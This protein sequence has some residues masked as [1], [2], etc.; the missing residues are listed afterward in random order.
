MTQFSSFGEKFIQPS[1]IT[2]LMAD[3]GKANAS[4]D[5]EICMLGGGNPASIPAV[6]TIFQNEMQALL[7]QPSDFNNMLGNYDGPNGS[8]LFIEN[9]T[10]LL[11]KRYK[12]D[13]SEKNICLTNGSQSSFFNLFNLFAGDMP[14]GKK[15]TILFPLAPE[16]IGYFDQGLS[17][18]MFK[19]NKPI[20][21]ELSDFEFKYYIDF[22]QLKID[23]SIAAICVSRPTN[24]TGNVLTDTEMQKLDE[25]TQE[26]QIPLIVD[27][28]YGFPFP[29]A[30]YTDV[31]PHWHENIILTMS[32]SK[33]GLPGT[34]TGIIIAR[35]DIINAM[36]S[37][38]AIMSLAPTS[39]GAN[40]VNRLMKTGEIIHLREDI[41]RP[42]YQDKSIFACQLAHSLFSDMPVKIHKSEGA[43]FLWLWCPDLPISTTVLYHRLA[44]RKVFVI[45]S[46][47]FFPNV[48]QIWQHP[49]ECLRITFT[50]PEETLKRGFKI[51]AEELRKAYS[52]AG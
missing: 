33:L 5:P 6:E 3:L 18:D 35:E 11:N 43:F 34:R 4:A 7:Q 14:N 38:N 24:P 15:K 42:F 29:G 40:L 41:I 50:Q 17:K 19:A 22:D 28:A 36:S 48:G 16:Y 32:L 31:N 51:I 20:I 44:E 12:W 47:H 1:G 10:R 26:H 39:I 23:D 30:I 52:Q 8:E 25:L 46:E 13:L 9:L 45:P 49:K 27:N 21:C 37:I 2:Q